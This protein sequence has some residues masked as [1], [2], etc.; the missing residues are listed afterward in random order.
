MRIN[1]RVNHPKFNKQKVVISI[2]LPKIG[3]KSKKKKK[4]KKN[5]ES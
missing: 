1:T 3:K 2:L 5:Y 4:R